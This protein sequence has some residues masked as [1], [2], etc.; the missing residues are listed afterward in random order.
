MV[1]PGDGQAVRVLQENSESGVDVYSFKRMSPK[2]EQVIRRQ[3]C[4]VSG[5]FIG[6]VSAA[7]V[8]MKSLMGIPVFGLR[9]SLWGQNRRWFLG[10][11]L[12]DIEVSG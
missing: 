7:P 11:G 10:S 8:T 6:L 12:N 1:I 2:I 4:G 9:D 3:G 5:N